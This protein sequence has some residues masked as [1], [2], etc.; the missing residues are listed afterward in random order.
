MAGGK[1]IA[2]AMSLILLSSAFL[3]I[4]N[5]EGADGQEDFDC[6]LYLYQQ[7]GKLDTIP[8]SG[9]TRV[10]E[11]MVMG[12]PEDYELLWPVTDD[13]PISGPVDSGS[14][15]VILHLE[16]GTVTPGST[17]VVL[18]IELIERKSTGIEDVIGSTQIEQGDL[19]QS[20]LAVPISGGTTISAGSVIRLVL[21]ITEG[22]GFTGLEPLYTFLY[23]SPTGGNSYLSFY[24]Q[25]IPDD[26]ISLLMTNPGGSEISEIL[27]NGPPETRT[28]SFHCGV[29]DHF[30]AYDVASINLLIR[31]PEGNI[32]LNRTTTD[33]EPGGGQEWTYYNFTEELP[34]SMPVGDYDVIITGISHTGFTISETFTLTAAEGLYVALDGPS[35]IE[36]DAGDI[37]IFG[38][39]ILNGGGSTDRLSFSSQDTRGWTVQ[40]PDDIDIEP[41]AELTV[42]F[43][44]TVPLKAR[45]GEESN[46]TMKVT[47]RNAGRMY[48]VS[49][50]IYVK[51][52][53]TFGIE[54]V[55][56]SQ[57]AVNPGMNA[58][59]QVRLTN[60][61]N[62]TKIFEMSVSGLPSTITSEMEADN[63]VQE[64]SYY[65]VEVGPGND[66]LVSIA[67][68]VSSSED[69]GTFE[70]K[71]NA[72]P[73]GG[74]EER[75]VYF[76]VLV[77]DPGMDVISV[78][79]GITEMTAPRS[80]TTTP[81]KYSSVS[82]GLYLYNP[83]LERTEFSV[84][85]D[86]PTG[87]DM[88]LDNDA[89]DL[90]P[91][92]GTGFNLS[93]TPMEGQLYV[94]DGG[95]DVRITV[96]GDGTT[97]SLDLVVKIRKIMDVKFEAE[98]PDV[99][100][101]VSEGK[102]IIVNMTVQNRG[103]T[104]V[105]LDFRIE[106]PP[107]LGV[108]MT[109]SSV[110]GLAPGDSED[111]KADV[112]AFEIDEDMFFSVSIE[113]YTDGLER[114]VTFQVNVRNTDDSLSI[115]PLI[116]IVVAVV[117]FVLLAA[118][119]FIYIRFSKKKPAAE[120][121]SKPAGKPRVEVTSIRQDSKETAKPLKAPPDR[122]ILKEADAITM[123]L[124]G[125]DEP[126]EEPVEAV[127][128]SILE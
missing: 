94:D 57:R 52:E 70:F 32:L 112:E 90:L 83:T 51:G 10:T 13:M 115:D 25:P 92:T 108:N 35:S 72:R 101:E 117:G 17:G 113:A 1:H 39:K 46:V 127:E 58:E 119:V 122:D 34:E 43:R 38:M 63:G 61:R 96:A 16:G 19:D 29:K 87:W 64:G 37:A 2:L 116:L 47:S 88:D 24:A 15:V 125:G 60:L 85:A 100:H 7:N 49:G 126:E 81:I 86:I 12:Q 109:P 89:A 118:G 124:L 75:S 59:Y 40:A 102:K 18:S 121:Q 95:F 76:S 68:A 98:K 42:E 105:D 120:Q 123:Q 107:E 91:G 65:N 21:N 62:D 36:V 28:V 110:N 20:D 69:G 73:R 44:V 82:F 8:P 5:L 128:V 77:V 6:R 45:I 30:G 104:I 48:T 114:D 93:V 78:P 80:G 22:E 53:A 54:A 84:D 111:L 23:Q 9:T 106:S 99:I 31:S 26:G 67:L 103:N 97:D 3:L 66:T 56:D 79:S 41:G 50:E 27:P 4:V 71:V 74:S 11:S 55:G 14:T 33:P